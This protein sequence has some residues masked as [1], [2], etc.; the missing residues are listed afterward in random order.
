[1]ERVADVGATK[2]IVV[3]EVSVAFGGT[4]AVDDVSVSFRTGEVVGLIGP[5]GAGKTTLL[6]AITGDVVAT[7]GT[8]TLDGAPLLGRRQQDIVRMGVG[9]TFQSPKVIPD[10]SLVENVM[11][12]GD[13]SGG[14]GPLRQILN[15]PKAVAVDRSSRERAM[16]LLEEFSLGARAERPAADQPYGVLRLVEIARNLM[17]DPAFLLLDEPGAGLTEFERDEVAAVVRALSQRDIGVVLVD[18]NLPLINLAC[19]RIYVLNTGRVLAE[20]H[21]A[22]VFAHQDVITAYLGVPG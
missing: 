20:G 10:L 9:R 6:N 1:V 5:N 16:A 19:D 7:S 18:H 17:L 4:R 21:P 12:A 14:A 22:E 3:S 11:L 15:S 13:G 8:I 2:E